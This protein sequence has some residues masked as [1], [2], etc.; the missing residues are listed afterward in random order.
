MKMIIETPHFRARKSLLAFV[1]EKVGK[2]ELLT[3]NII[4]SRVFMKLDKTGSWDNK[5]C[6]IQLF[7]PGNELFAS[8][9]GS[10]FEEAVMQTIEAL[11]R[12]VDRWK[13]TIKKKREKAFTS[14]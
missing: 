8:S 7:V 11:R 14:I 3:G 5:V 12:Q 10:T 6:E 2:L 13:G 9:Q 1:L 4:E